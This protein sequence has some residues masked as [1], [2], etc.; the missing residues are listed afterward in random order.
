MIMRIVGAMLM[1]A[2]VGFPVVTNAKV[3]LGDTC[4]PTGGWQNGLK[5]KRPAAEMRTTSDG[6]DCT[7]DTSNPQA[8]V[9]A[10]TCDPSD[11]WETAT[12]AECLTPSPPPTY[13]IE[14]RVPD[15]TTNVTIERLRFVCKTA[16]TDI[17]TQ[18]PA[19][20]SC[21]TEPFDPPQEDS[22]S[23]CDCSDRQ[24]GQ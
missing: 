1:A 24:P 6:S 10:G 21:Q 16:S 14:C 7:L 15:G 11:A 22:V 2:G 23:K 17:E 19:S 3:L 8:P 20:C 4:F 5:C 18:L 9:C 13:A 12:N